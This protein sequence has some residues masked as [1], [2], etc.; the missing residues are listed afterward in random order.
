PASGSVIGVNSN[1]LTLVSVS[2]GSGGGYSVIV[3]NA[4]GV[5]TSSIAAL[6]VVFPPSIVTQPTN[7]DILVGG[8]AIFT[9]SASGALPLTYQWRKGG[10]NLNNGGNV[11]GATSNTLTLTAVTPGDSGNYTLFVTNVYGSTTSSVAS[12]TVDQAPTITLPLVAQ[13]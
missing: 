7:E 8:T 13:T 5:V 10:T 6:T 1:V 9:A 2:A 4:S 3:T 11:T 12:L